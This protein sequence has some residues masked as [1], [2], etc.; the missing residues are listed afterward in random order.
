MNSRSTVSQPVIALAEFEQNLDHI[1]P[2]LL[3]VTHC[4]NFHFPPT[5]VS[6][7]DMRQEFA[8]AEVSNLWF[9]GG[10]KDLRFQDQHFCAQATYISK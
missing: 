7:F 4:A 8:Q 1:I 2:R 6:K 10:R 3:G 9:G 5:L